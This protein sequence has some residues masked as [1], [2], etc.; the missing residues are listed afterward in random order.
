MI[1]IKELQKNKS[2]NNL[3]QSPPLNKS[4][5]FKKSNDSASIEISFPISKNYSEKLLAN[6]S[7]NKVFRSSAPEGKNI[8]LDLRKKL[9]E[10]IKLLDKMIEDEYKEN[11]KKVKR[12]KKSLS[13]EEAKLNDF[14]EKKNV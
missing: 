2:L 6:S 10:D 12:N 3:K 11:K 13:Y 7:L 4:N 5:G 14:L 1:N 9:K 8:F